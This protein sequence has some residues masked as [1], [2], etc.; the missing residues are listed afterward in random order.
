MGK[1]FDRVWSAI[2]DGLVRVMNI[3]LTTKTIEAVRINNRV[4]YV[5]KC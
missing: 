2:N 1:W 4:H 5:G 3:I